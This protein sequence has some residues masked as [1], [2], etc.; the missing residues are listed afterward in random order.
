MVDKFDQERPQHSSRRRVLQGALGVGVCQ[1]LAGAARAQPAAAP[2]EALIARQLPVAGEG[3]EHLG[4]TVRDVTPAARFFGRVFN[5]FL[6]KEQDPPLRYYVTLDP[7]YIA[8]GG[9][10]SRTSGVIDHDCVLAEGYDRAAMAV[11]LEREGFAQGNRGIFADADGL[12]LQL[13]AGGGLA[14][15]TEP[16]GRLVDGEPLV[17]PRG[18]H[19]VLRLVTDLDRSTAF[20]RTILGGEPEMDAEGTWFRIGSTRFGIRRVSAGE[21][22]RIDRFCVNVAAGGFDRVAVVKELV[23][24]GAKVVED[25]G[26]YLHFRSPDGIG[27]ELRPVDP[28]K[29]WDR[30]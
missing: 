6:Y 2:P 7:G 17:R 25:G 1:L 8:I 20:Y 30:T 16:A 13:L 27:V 3:L 21:A 19:R 28:A 5:P 11:R 24:L 22:P 26:P 14:V 10:E 15:T 18:L 4:V 12:R 9:N 23:T 29:L